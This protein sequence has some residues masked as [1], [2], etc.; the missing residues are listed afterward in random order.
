MTAGELL[1]QLATD[2][3]YQAM[4]LAKD[5][6]LS[7]IAE[8]RRR[9]QQ[10]LLSDLSLAGATVDWVG[11]LLE[12]P[13]PDDRIY[14]V[15]LDHITRSYP[16]WLLGWIGRAFGRKSARPIVWDRLINLIQTHALGGGAVEGVMIAISEMAKPSDLQT[17]IELLSDTSLGS[18]RMF[19][20]R[21]LTRSK[22]PE[23]RSALLRNQADPDLTKEITA[24]L[25]RSRD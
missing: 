9:E 11:Q 5:L 16:A 8:E 24:R 15:L 2:P 23:A 6:E 21:N 1:S 14:P 4:R 18:S 12:M 20:V 7:R 3:E 10:P 19:L 17:L 25:S 22:R 13:A